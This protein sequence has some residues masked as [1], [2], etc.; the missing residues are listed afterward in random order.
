MAWAMLALGMFTLK[1][2]FSSIPSFVL[3]F[4]LITSPISGGSF[5]IIVTQ[6]RIQKVALPF[7]FAPTRTTGI[8]IGGS[9]LPSFTLLMFPSSN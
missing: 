3:R 7:T 1:V 9:F 4:L 8:A 2:P 6:A 5:Y